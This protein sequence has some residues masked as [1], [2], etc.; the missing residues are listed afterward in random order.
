MLK[1]IDLKYRLLRYIFRPYIDLA[2]DKLHIEDFKIQLHFYRS[3][4]LVS[5]LTLQS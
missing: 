4:E 1:T 2:T 5:V 3:L